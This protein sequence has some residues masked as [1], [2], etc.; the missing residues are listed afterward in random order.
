MFMCHSVSSWIHWM[1]K[2]NP[3]KLFCRQTTTA[4][5]A[6]LVAPTPTLDSIFEEERKILAISLEFQVYSMTEM[7]ETRSVKS[8]TQHT[9]AMS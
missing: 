4:A 2:Q 5:A 8:H 3:I 9:A 7:R 6:M 1:Y